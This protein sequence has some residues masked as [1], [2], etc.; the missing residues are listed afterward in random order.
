M[1][2]V[3]TLTRVQR[4]ALLHGVYCIVNES[5]DC[6]RIA[7]DALA[8][9]V[10]ILQYRAKLGISGDT[11]RALR[12]LSR[13][14]AALLVVNDDWRAAR[15][16]DCDGVHLGPDDDG[17]RA[18]AAVRVALGEGL[19]GLSCGTAAE[20]RDADA[21]DADYAGVGPVY[22]TAS[23]DD[24]GEPIGIDG[25]KEV[26]AAT[27]LPVAAIG[28]ITG[29]N[30]AAVRESGVAMAAVISAI[31]DAPDR[32]SAAERLVCAWEAQP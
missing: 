18:V 19:I 7:G 14:H 6:V 12:E 21:S 32:M 26:A 2:A 22:A 20:A 16:F 31:A 23:K 3:P 28:G 29:E 27:R 11:V 8:G 5:A 4:R 15:D 17:F 30:V 25:L 13:A 9:G 1:A 10:R 24:A